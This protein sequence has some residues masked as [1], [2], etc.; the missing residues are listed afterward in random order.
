M[1]VLHALRHNRNCGV[2]RRG[3]DARMRRPGRSASGL[4]RD[5]KRLRAALTSDQPRANDE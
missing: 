1:N 2:A 5:G 4:E 3:L